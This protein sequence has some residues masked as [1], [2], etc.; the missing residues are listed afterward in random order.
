MQ[1][2]GADALAS[3]HGLQ[4]DLAGRLD[5]GSYLAIP[6][7]LACQRPISD[8]HDEMLFIVIHQATEL[9]IKLML[10]ELDAARLQIAADRLGPC[11]KM[12]ARVSRIQQQL[13]QAWDVLSTLT[14]SDYLVFRHRLGP[15]SGFQSHQYRRLEFLLGNRDTRKLAVF[16]HQP[17]LLGE[18]EAECARPTLYDEALR[19]LARRGLPIDP[20]VLSRDVSRP[21]AA[22]PSVLAAWERVY[23]RSAE[24]F[25]L[26]ELAEELVDL[27]DAFRQW[28]FRH[29]TT[30]ERVIGLKT[31]TGGT[32][33]VGYLRRA[34]DYVLFPELWQV[35][36]VL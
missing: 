5:Y 18:L 32:S 13:V 4:A 36:T 27:E 30:V 31:G 1:H 35:R 3:E 7:L 9:W 10:H 11:F 17:A 29:L 28:R 16:R 14:P 22:Q 24:L 25:D 15:A 6:E 2:G 12:T 21:Y 33:G 8:S 23:R 26:Y 20:G 19:L 34:L